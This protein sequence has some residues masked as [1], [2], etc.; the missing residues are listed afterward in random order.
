MTASRATECQTG[1]TVDAELPGHVLAIAN[2]DV[3]LLGPAE[4]LELQPN[5]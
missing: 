2:T 3:S 1:K 5:L 4:A